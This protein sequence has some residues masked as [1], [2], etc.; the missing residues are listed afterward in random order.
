[1]LWAGYR[2]TSTLAVVAVRLRQVALAVRD[3]V[4]VEAEVVEALGVEPCIHD[5]GV[6]GFG[7]NNVLFPVGECLLELVSPFRDGTTAGRYLDRR[8]GD[9]GYMVIFQVEDLEVVRARVEN[10]D[11]RIVLEAVHPGI[12][13]IH[14]HPRD[15]GG[16]IVSVDRTDRWEDWPWAG[17][18]W[19]EHVRTDVVSDL[20]AVEVA[21]AEPEAV[22]VIWAAVLGVDPHGAV[23]HLDDGA[24]RF[25]PIDDRGEGVLGVELRAASRADLDVGGVRMAL[26]P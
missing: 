14:L 24:V 19:R 23:V 3:L 8:G 2:A 13:G 21:V 22:A 7:L 5:F 17:S 10:L 25:V 1:M 15:V 11:L 9:T 12:A 20:V 16:A 4:A 6:E 18:D 26:R